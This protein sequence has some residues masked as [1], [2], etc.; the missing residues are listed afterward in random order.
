[1][2]YGPGGFTL[3][4]LKAREYRTHLLAARANRWMDAQTR[5]VAVKLKLVNLNDANR[6]S[7]NILFERQPAGAHAST[8]TGTLRRREGQARCLAGSCPPS[9]TTST[10]IPQGS[11]TSTVVE[12]H[13]AFLTFAKGLYWVGTALEYTR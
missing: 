6:L 4:M 5:A 3:D 8:Q 9:P 13:V 11:H 1:M 7:V 12:Q 2:D 10:G